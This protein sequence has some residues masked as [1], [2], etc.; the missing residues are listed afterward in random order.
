VDCGFNTETGQRLRKVVQVDEYDEFAGM[1][2]TEKMMARAEDAI[3]DMPITG[4]GQDFGD[5]GSAALVA[6][7]AGAILVVLVA[8]GLT[9]VLTMETLTKTIISPGAVSFLASLVLI[10]AM[11]IW[12]T[13][14]A[15]KQ[16]TTQ[17][18]VCVLTGGLWC[19]VYGFSQGRQLITPTVILLFSFVIGLG[20]G[21]YVYLNGFAPPP[22]TK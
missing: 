8:I 6:L 21:Y 15:F 4:V 16:N 12:I 1:S 17:G 7:I 9:V 18:I 20:A 19:I 22:V 2:E 5:G 13:I 11:S 3:D 14:V 10:V